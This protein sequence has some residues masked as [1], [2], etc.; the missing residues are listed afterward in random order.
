[1][2]CERKPQERILMQSQLQSSERDI[3]APGVEQHW[4]PAEIAGMWGVDA[5]IVRRLFKNEPGI[6]VF[7]TLA[8]KGKRPYK[9]I[10]IPQTVFDRVYRRLQT[11]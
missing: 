2:N 10:R 4:S 9:T 3:N 11:T 8:K 5:E 7:Q 6:I 1:M